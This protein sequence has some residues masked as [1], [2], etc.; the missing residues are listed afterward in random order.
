MKQK[1]DEGQFIFIAAAVAI[2]MTAGLYIDSLG[3]TAAKYDA[4]K[5]VYSVEIKKS[6][7]PQESEEALKLTQE[8]AVY[9]TASGTRFHIKNDCGQMDPQK[10]QQVTVKQALA[11]GLTPC[12]RCLKDAVIED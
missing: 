1:R 12:K 5:S 3:N 4:G 2:V 10:A 6:A 7:Q 9:I 11:K 8:D